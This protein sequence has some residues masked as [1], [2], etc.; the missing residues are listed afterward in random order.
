M[1]CSSRKS[2]L[3]KA[4]GK[5]SGDGE[6]M[7][8]SRRSVSGCGPGALT[9]PCEQGQSWLQHPG[10]AP[11]A[12]RYVEGIMS[13]HCKTDMAVNSDPELQTWCQEIIEIGLPRTEGFLSLYRL[14]T[15]FATLSPCV[16]SPALPDNPPST[17]TRWLW[18]SIRRS[19][20][21]A[22]GVRLC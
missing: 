2:S 16:S 19:I 21:R 14:R 1:H 3:G 9:W 12:G 17:W 15:R 22:L 18:A 6:E 4:S 7:S 8:E 13:L 5:A 11:L 20:F 10:P